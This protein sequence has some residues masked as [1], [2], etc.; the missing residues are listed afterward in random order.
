MEFDPGS[1]HDWMMLGLSIAIFLVMI[2]MARIILP[3]FLEQ[4]M[5]WGTNIREILEAFRIELRPPEPYRILEKDRKRGNKVHLRVPM[6][7]RFP[8]G[9]A[10]KRKHGPS[11]FNEKPIAEEDFDDM[12]EIVGGDAPEMAW[13]HDIEFRRK[14][15]DLRWNGPCPF[16]VHGWSVRA[17]LKRT[18]DIHQRKVVE[19][20]V[21]MKAV[22]SLID[23]CMAGR[24]M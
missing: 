4:G 17:H 18:P 1:A 7:R 20:E 12:F 14:L 16:D 2:A 5:T 10:I 23:A 21:M 11:Y 22:A 8:K 3:V 24:K 15:I 13:M 19:A 9:C 6:K